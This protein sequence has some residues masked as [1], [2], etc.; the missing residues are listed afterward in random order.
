MKRWIMHVDMD[1][2]YAS[3]EQRDNPSYKGHPVIVGGLSERGVV[4]TA[5]YEARAFGIHSAMPITQARK[6]CPQGIFLR[7]RIYHY[8]AISQQ[9]HE[10]MERFTPYIEP[11][12]LD[13]AFLEVSGMGALYNTP[14]EMGLAFKEQVYQATGLV[15]S[16]GIGPNKFI[17]KLA[18]DWQK[19]NGLVIVPVERVQ[20]FLDPLPIRYLWGVGKRTAMQ[21]AKGGFTHIHHVATLPDAS[22]LVPFCGKQA[23]RLYEL[24]HGIDNRPVAYDREAQSIG[25]EETYEED[26][27]DALFI[28]REWR[29]FAHKVAKRLRKAKLMGQT[30]GIK[31]RWADFTTVTR[32]KKLDSPTNSEDTLY[33]MS[34]LLYNKVKS[35]DSVR[36]LGITV[37]GLV[38]EV[39]QDSLF[40]ETNQQSKLARTMDALEA[41]FGEGTV[42]KGS[43][44]ERRNLEQAKKTI[45][46]LT[47]EKESH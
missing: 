14:R 40:V 10:I 34:Q 13:E 41:R 19:P 31:V 9:I 42:M 44:W 45:V 28:D 7:P 24:A 12:S 1:A 32:Q 38:P 20:T 5:S 21:L 17:A 4:A 18:S 2:F 39:V 15:V 23:Q 26:M 16:V 47:G 27:T 3:V 43:L 29:Y 8:R 35:K 30:I 25:N 36:L 46:R 6:L 33:S 37:S 22:A 11:L